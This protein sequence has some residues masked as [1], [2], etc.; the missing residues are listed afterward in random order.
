MAAQHD[1]SGFDLS[2]FVIDRDADVPIGVQLA[3]A[4]RTRIQ[5]GTYKP[6]QR[7]PGLRELAE[8]IEVN[9]NTVKA[10][11][12]RLDQEGLLESQQGSGTFVRS[13]PQRPADVAAIVANAV[14]EA[15]ETGVDPRHVAAALYVSQG[16]AQSSDMAGERRRLLRTQIASLERALGE[17]EAEHP[18]VAPPPEVQPSAGPALL[19]AEE[20]EQIRTQLVRR[21]ATV[22]AAID[23]PDP[24][25]SEPPAAKPRQ[26][27]QPTLVEKPKPKSKRSTAGPRPTPRPASASG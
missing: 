17:I 27:T 8:A 22:Q 16:P 23:E 18:G 24:P 10:V 20:L 5:D 26:S 19:G 9:V 3:W 4:L 12:R 21:L 2:E 14:R 11:Y 25:D 6:G 15:R 1:Q 7:L 13:M